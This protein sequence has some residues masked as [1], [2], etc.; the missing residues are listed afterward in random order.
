MREL[1]VALVVVAPGVALACSPLGE[2]TWVDG[3]EP[4]GVLPPAP[5]ILGHEVTRPW[6]LFYD[7]NHDGGSLE[8]DC[9]APRSGGAGT[10]EF[11]V[12][13]PLGEVAVMIERVGG[14]SPSYLSGLSHPP[15][16]LVPLLDP[17]LTWDG[18][19]DTRVDFR[20]RMR[21][22]DRDG[23]VSE[24]SETYHVLDDGGRGCSAGGSRAAPFAPL[25]VAVALGAC[26]TR[27]RPR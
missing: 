11:D 3:W 22:V 2:E 24:W 21:T 20:V 17:V 12:D 9:S 19:D 15:G 13:A 7:P 5:H 14:G 25:A 1:L 8:P 27:R 23:D 18:D 6:K 26:R 16:P 10:V 4:D